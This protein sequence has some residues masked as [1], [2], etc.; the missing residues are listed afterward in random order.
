MLWE[1]V[2]LGLSLGAHVV[3]SMPTFMDRPQPNDAAWYRWFYAF[4]NAV[5]QNFGKARNAVL[6]A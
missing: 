1:H 5:A 2:L 6:P 4:A 3:A